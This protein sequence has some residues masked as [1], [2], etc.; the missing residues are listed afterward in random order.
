MNDFSADVAV[1]GLGPAGRAVAHRCSAAGLDVLVVDPHPHRAWTPTYSAWADE[2]PSWLPERW[3]R[4]TRTPEVWTDRQETHRSHLLRTEYIF[5]A[6]HFS[7]ALDTSAGAYAL[8]HRRLTGLGCVDG[9]QLTGSSSSTPEGPIGATRAADRLRDVVDRA[10][11]DPILGGSDAWFMDWRTDNGTS[12]A[13]TPRF[14]YAVALDDD[15]VLLE[16]TCLVGRP[17]F[18]LREL[19]TRLRTR[20]HNRGCEVPDDAPVE[21]VRFAVEGPKDSSP[22]GVLRFGGRGGLMHPGTGY[23]VASSL[24]EADTVAKAIA[25]GDD[26]NAALWP[27]SAKAVSA[28]RRVGL[29]AL[30]TLDSG[31]VTTFF[32]KFFDLPVEAQRSLPF[33]SAGRGRDGEG[34]GNTVPIVT[35][36][37]EKDVDARAVSPVTRSAPT[38]DPHRLLRCH[39]PSDHRPGVVQIVLPVA[40][41]MGAGRLEVE[42]GRDL[43]LGQAVR[44][45]VGAVVGGRLDDA[46]DDRPGWRG[47]R[48]AVDRGVVRG[49]R[50]GR[51][52]RS[53]WRRRAR[54][55]GASRRSRRDRCR[56]QP[57]PSS[58]PHMLVDVGTAA[59]AGRP[60][61]WR[62]WP[63][64]CWSRRSR[65]TTR[66]PCRGPELRWRG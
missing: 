43:Q 30:L 6:D 15:R 45:V 54:C 60:V 58:G 51:A 66:R 8:E 11:A 44:E 31:E 39:R 37:R 12:A 55:R 38:T 63:T 23:S 2:L 36:A 24:A 47:R 52:A 14:L 57:G 18:G 3:S 29:N 65:C 61:R 1:V 56:I 49:C 5:A 7:P 40:P 53:R 13:D 26:P 32:D 19:E 64:G 21:R 59:H 17:A 48:P 16:E 33:R 20:L 10:L 4:P 27:R 34:D 46:A 28:L 41:R 25:D 22:D 9:S 50:A 62:Y 35:V 42:G